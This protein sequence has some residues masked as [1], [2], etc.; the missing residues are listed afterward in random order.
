MDF[1]VNCDM[2]CTNL[3]VNSVCGSNGKTYDSQCALEQASCLNG[4]I[5]INQKKSSIHL[6]Y[7]GNCRG[8]WMT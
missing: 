4:N 3:D 2:K 6:L 7:E 5:A 8:R 1:S